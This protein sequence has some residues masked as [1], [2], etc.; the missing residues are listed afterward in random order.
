VVDLVDILKWGREIGRLRPR[1]GEMWQ[2]RNLHKM[3]AVCH[4]ALVAF[5]H[6]ST[7]LVGIDTV[8][9]VVVQIGVENAYFWTVLGVKN[10]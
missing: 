8:V 4:H 2:F 1:L 5:M 6:A 10:E 7:K 3:P 9:S